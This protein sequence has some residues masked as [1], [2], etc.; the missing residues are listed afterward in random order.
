MHIPT[1]KSS[2]LDGGDLGDISLRDEFPAP[3]PAHAQHYKSSGLEDQ[4]REVL[5]GSDE[6]DLDVFSVQIT[7]PHM[8]GVKRSAATLT[9]NNLFSVLVITSCPLSSRLGPPVV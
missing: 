3:S 4:Q 5:A 2:S 1:L 8:Q 6:G 9:G 7:F